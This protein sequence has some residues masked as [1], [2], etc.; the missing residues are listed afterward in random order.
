MLLKIVL[1]IF[2]KY[3]INAVELTDDGTQVSVGGRPHVFV[4]KGL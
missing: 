4:I 1:K 3:S 2:R